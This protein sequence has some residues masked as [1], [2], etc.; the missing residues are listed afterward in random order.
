MN[1]PF[2]SFKTLLATAV[3][4]VFLVACAST[5]RPEGADNARNKLTQLQAD[6]QLASRAPV[7]IKE[8]EAAVSAAEKPQKDKEM[9]AHLVAM[10]DRKVDIAIAQAQARLAEDQRKQLSEQRESARLEAR[11]READ[12]AR[13]EATSAR[14]DANI[15]KSQASTARTEADIA[16]NEAQAAGMATAAA[17]QQTEDLQRQIAELNA[18]PTDRGLVVTLGDVLF[19]TGRSELK[20][21]AASNL[22]KLAAFLTKYP[23]RTVVIEGHT[24]SVGSEESNLALSQRRA[25][26]VKSWLVNQGVAAE[27]LVATGKGESSPV[28]GNASASSRQQNRR[29]EVIISNPAT[30]SP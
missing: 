29:V 23:E 12:K 28:A 16:R 27:R 21:G 10:A 6:P 17:M 5:P 14:I 15:A 13:S 8:A 18:K 4:S 30:P 1:M 25:D 2:P 26:A 20:G 9:E 19:A 22:G 3:A 24:D 11:T 7:A